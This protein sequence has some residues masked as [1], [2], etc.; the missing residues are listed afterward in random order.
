MGKYPIQYM[1][2][3]SAQELKRMRIKKYLVSDR[4]K[5]KYQIASFRFGAYLHRF[6]RVV[7]VPQGRNS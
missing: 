4:D 7:P 6:L 5:T 3:S 1:R 2:I